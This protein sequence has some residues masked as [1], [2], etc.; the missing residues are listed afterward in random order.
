MMND[1]KQAKADDEKNYTTKVP[2]EYQMKFM[3]NRNLGDLGILPEE[4]VNS[5]GSH[6]LEN[7]SRFSDK[8]LARINKAYNL[9]TQNELNL[10]NQIRV[11][12]LEE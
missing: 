1:S 9:K 12:Y 10:N 3:S 4:D 7:S 5:D 11:A 6:S 2:M 8:S